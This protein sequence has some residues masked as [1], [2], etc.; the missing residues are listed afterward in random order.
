MSNFTGFIGGSSSV[1]K[2]IQ[3]VSMGG[4]SSGSATIS[5]VDLNKTFITLVSSSTKDNTYY[6]R[7][8]TVTS[9][10]VSGYWGG[11]YQM[12]MTVYVVEYN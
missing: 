6:P 1:I 8:G 11:G 7:V 4:S 12:G 10:S 3:K 9:T 5:A 2:S